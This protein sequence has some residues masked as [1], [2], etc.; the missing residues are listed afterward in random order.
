MN[1]QRLWQM[2][3]D[4]KV[5]DVL[6]NSHHAIPYIQSVHL[7]GIALLLGSM[8]ILNFRLLGIGLTAIRIEVI[9]KQVWSWGTVGLVM[10]VASGFFVFLP[11]PARYAA[12]TS[13]LVKMVTLLVAVLFQYTIYRRAVKAKVAAHSEQKEVL[14]PLVSLFLWFGVGWMGRAIAFLG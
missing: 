11:D 10:A 3:Y 6:R 12:N 5:I 1:L 4:S 14:L 9:A 2:S 8:V 13:F 7:L